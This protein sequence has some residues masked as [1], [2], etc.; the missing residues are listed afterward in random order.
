MRR[1][2]GCVVLVLASFWGA[3]CGDG[4]DGGGPSG[5]GTESG[6]LAGMT[7]AHNAVRRAVGEDLP[8]LTWD[9]ELA[10]VAQGW[11]ERLASRG[12]SLQHSDSGYGE[13]LA[14]FGGTEASPENVVGLWEAERACYTFGPFM[15]GDDCSGDCG[16][17]GHYTQVVWRNS[18]R[19]GCGVATCDGGREIWTCNY[20]PPG[21][22]LGQEPY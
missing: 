10:R 3:G 17:C 21:N 2:L 20:D 7:A 4:G 9:P 18:T 22:F 16:A 1:L 12:C 6:R 15:R 11:S 19:L 8:D 5:S 13:N 14:F